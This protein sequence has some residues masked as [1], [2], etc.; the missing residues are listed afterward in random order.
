MTLTPTEAPPLRLLYSICLLTPPQGC[1]QQPWELERLQLLDIILFFGGWGG[2]GCC[3]SSAHAG[4]YSPASG[5]TD[6]SFASR[7]N[8]QKAHTDVRSE[9]ATAMTQ[10]ERFH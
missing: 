9:G 1:L 6:E 5:E 10:D 8:A 7:T 4:W 2:N 3:Y